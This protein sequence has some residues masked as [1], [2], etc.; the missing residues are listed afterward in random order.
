MGEL[1]ITEKKINY[2]IVRLQC[3]MLCNPR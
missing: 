3:H 1:S 2:I